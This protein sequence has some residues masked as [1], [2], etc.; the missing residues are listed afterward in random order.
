MTIRLKLLFSSVAVFVVVF[1]AGVVGAAPADAVGLSDPSALDVH[2]GSITVTKDGTVIEDLEIRG[3]LR[4]EADDV[5]VR[6]VWVYTSNPWT[7]YVASGSATFDDIEVGHPK[8]WGL[9]GIGGSNVTVRDADIHH[10]EDGIKLGSNAV[11][12]NV[13]VHDLASPEPGPHADA[14][15]VEGTARNSIVKNSYLDST[16]KVG[17]GNAAIFVKSDIGP[18]SNLVFTNNYLNGG[19]YTV[20][21]K[22]GGN[23]VPKNVQIINNRFG[24]DRRY[25]FLSQH[26]PVVWENNTWADTG[27]V[28]DTKGKTNGKQRSSASPKP[29]IA[30]F[31]DIATSVHKNDIVKLVDAK[32]TRTS[33]TYRPN[34]DISR[35]EAAAFLRR[36]LRLPDAGKDYFR[37]DN[38]SAFESDINA[39]AARGIASTSS[40]FFRP[41]DSVTRGE[42]A[43]FV[44][45]ALDLR[46]G[47]P[48]PFVDIRTSIYRGDIEAIYRADITR[49]TSRTTYSPRDDVT[50][51][52]M[53]TFMVRAFGL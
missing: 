14:I 16:G 4:I 28:I 39:L 8:I 15:Q 34:S 37:D 42:M 46:S 9:R 2:E 17:V 45:R 52:Q 31:T 30:G 25:G 53:A 21:V 36:A 32:I 18:Q 49:G 35:G 12:S 26:G 24:P 23:G 22:D 19:N 27:E 41:N 20:Y 11:Y 1:V 7:I 50:R 33:G 47:G 29:T 40:R 6:N 44:A 10:V 48:S 51:G 5:V 43:A 3:T 13:R 38:S